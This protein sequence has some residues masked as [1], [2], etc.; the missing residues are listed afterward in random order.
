V[1]AI[2]QF[3]ELVTEPAVA[4]RGNYHLVQRLG[5]IGQQIE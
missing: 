3:D 4:Q 2:G 1:A 5:C